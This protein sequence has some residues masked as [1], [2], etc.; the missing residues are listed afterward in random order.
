MRNLC[1]EVDASYHRCEKSRGFFE[2]FYRKFFDKSADIPPKFSLTDMEKQKQVVMASVLTCLRMQ[3]GDEVARMAVEEIGERHSRRERDIPPKMYG[4]WLD[5]LCE[6]IRE[7]DPE[8]SPDLE[9]SWRE[10]M[11]P[12]IEIITS[13]Y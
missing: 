3:S 4:L 6:S 7:H 1:D 5:A 9:A 10:A 12:S 2:T 11:R 13:K 8:Y